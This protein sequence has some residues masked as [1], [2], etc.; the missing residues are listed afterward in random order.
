MTG[1]IFLTDT[2][3][4]VLGLLVARPDEGQRLEDIAA[5]LDMDRTRAGQRLRTLVHHRLATSVYTLRG[6]VFH[7]TPKGVQHHSQRT[8][9]SP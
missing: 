2:E 9:S 3:H 6:R 5:E 8:E 4:R 7:P 1:D